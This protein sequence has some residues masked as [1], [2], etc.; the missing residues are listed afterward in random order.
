MREFVTAVKAAEQVAAGE[1][2]PKPITVKIDGRETTFYPP[3]AE[4]LATLMALLG[5]ADD[6][7]LLSSAIAYFIEMLG[8]EDRAWYQARL[9]RRDDPFDLDMVADIIVGLIEEW[10]GTPTELPSG[11]TSSSGGTGV[12]STGSV[13]PAV[14]IR[15]G[16]RR[17][18]S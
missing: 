3:S 15:P 16:S 11:S 14:P 2:D 1:D 12:S 6:M 13:Q 5:T 9:L 17:V 4:M 18:A 7:R 10:S 8:P